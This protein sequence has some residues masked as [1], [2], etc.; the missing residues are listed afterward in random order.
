MTVCKHGIPQ[1]SCLL[2]LEER[3]AKAIQTLIQDHGGNAKWRREHPEIWTP[4]R[5][6]HINLLQRINRKKRKEKLCGIAN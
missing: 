4:E 1:I 2:C 3:N 6:A 5:R